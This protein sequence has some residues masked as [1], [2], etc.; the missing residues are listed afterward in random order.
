MGLDY[1][2]FDMLI[3]KSQLTRA[4]CLMQIGS[5]CSTKKWR[6]SRALAGPTKLGRSHI[7]RCEGC[8]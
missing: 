4:I 5:G 1:E 2:N 8:V 7:V 3:A 6:K